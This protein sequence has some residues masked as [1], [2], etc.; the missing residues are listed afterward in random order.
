MPG[1]L[2]IT[3]RALLLAHWLN[4]AELGIKEV[5]VK[6][7][8]SAIPLHE[9]PNIFEW[10]ERRLKLTSH[11]KRTTAFVPH[12]TALR[13]LLTSLET[14]L[15]AQ[16]VQWLDKRLWRRESRR[17]SEESYTFPLYVNTDKTK[18]EPWI[19]YVVYRVRDLLQRQ[20]KFQEL[21]EDA[22][23]LG[24]VLYEGS[25]D[26]PFASIE[27][28]F[29]S[30]TVGAPLSDQTYA[31]KWQR[32]MVG[33]E[34]FFRATTSER[35]VEFYTLKATRSPDNQPIRSTTAGRKLVIAR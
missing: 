6:H 33:F 30:A 10:R 2:P 8:S 29:R 22:D 3:P 15:R 17:V 19:T 5:T 14:G 23:A 32:I 11:Q 18:E 12:C 35:H 20:E 27:P 34:A 25:P 9:I 26:T 21:F 1:M 24:P 7:G 28:L 13:L 16:S 31:D 4:L